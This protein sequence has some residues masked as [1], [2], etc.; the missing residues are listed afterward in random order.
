MFNHSLASIY[1][2][3]KSIELLWLVMDVYDRSSNGTL[4]CS[5]RL[6]QSEHVPEDL[7]LG[8]ENTS[9]NAKCN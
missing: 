9:V 3:Q 8:A 4:R 5:V 1:V 2:I 7:R 6:S